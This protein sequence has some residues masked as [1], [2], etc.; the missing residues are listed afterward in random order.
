MHIGPWKAIDGL[1]GAPIKG[2]VKGKNT[3]PREKMTMFFHLHVG[4]FQS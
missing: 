3:S 2:L 4:R 1:M